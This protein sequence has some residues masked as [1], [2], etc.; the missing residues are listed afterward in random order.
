MAKLDAVEIGNPC[1]ADIMTSDT[2]AT[3]AFYTELLGWEAEEPDEEFGGYFNF[4]KDGARIAGAMANQGGGMP[5]LW[6]IY[7]A[8]ADA[9][10]TCE[11]VVKAGGAVMVEPMAVGT[12]GTMA[13]VAEPTGAVIGMWQPGDHKGFGY[14]AEPGAPGW[15][16]LFTRDYEA[17]RS[18]YTDAFG[19]DLHK[20][21][22]EA[23]FKYSTLHEG[24]AQAAG[25]M[26]ASGFLPAE[27]PP[28]W[29]IYFA[30]DDVDA[31]LAKVAELGGSVE[32]PAEDTPYG[33]LA[34]A[35][36]PT[37]ARFKLMG[38][39]AAG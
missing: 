15:F 8:V 18:F 11:A 21:S 31:A 13:V 34:T 38:P 27:V 4:T 35:I 33:R 22:D 6:S 28:H 3:R 16:E 25:I 37:G 39:N 23:D 7:L 30:V 26:D 24:D 2:A 12:L 29:S 1:W 14:V 10:A 9:T 5:D 32:V 17:S 19:W 36:D 20:V